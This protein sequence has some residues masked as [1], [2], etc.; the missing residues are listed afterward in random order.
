MELEKL[1]R[2]FR[3]LSSTPGVLEVWQ[4]VVPTLGITGKQTHDAHLVAVMEVYS[5]N[6]I[7]TFNTGHFG[8]FSNIAVIDP[9]QIRPEI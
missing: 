8:R 6:N 4:R 2:L 1:R 5:I 3:V 9:A 7:L